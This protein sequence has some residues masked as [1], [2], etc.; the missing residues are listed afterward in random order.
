MNFL[1]VKNIV[2]YA[3]KLIEIWYLLISEK[4]FV[5]IFSGMG[6]TVFFEPKR[7]WKDDIYLKVLILTFSG[8]GNTVL[9]LSQKFMEIWYLLITE[10]SLF[11]TFWWWEI[12]SFFQSRSWWKDDIYWLLR[13]SCFELFGDGKYGLFSAKMLIERWYLLDLFELS[14]IFQDLGNM[15]FRTVLEIISIFQSFKN[16][17]V[18]HQIVCIFLFFI[19]LP[20]PRN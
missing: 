7:W 12:R 3:E 1:E 4:L 2:F 8:M 19:Q 6:N 14:M 10:K 9:F 18:D 20:F 16:I 15:V 13:S 17:R 11:W 5:L